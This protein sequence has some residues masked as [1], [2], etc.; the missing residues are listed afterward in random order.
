MICQHSVE[1]RRENYTKKAKETFVVVQQNWRE[2]DVTF[3]F[4]LLLLS[5]SFFSSLLSSSLKAKKVMLLQFPKDKWKVFLLLLPRF[6]PNWKMK[7]FFRSCC[8]F[9][10]TKVLLCNCQKDLST[11]V[12]EFPKGERKIFLLKFVASVSRKWKSS[13]SSSPI[14]SSFSSSP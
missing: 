8:C 7:N 6:S 3:S 2:C 11:C 10:S 9:L 4:L 14:S 13:L 1:K 12:V 5:P